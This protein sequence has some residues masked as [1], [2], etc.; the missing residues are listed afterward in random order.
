MKESGE[1]VSMIMRNSRKP[2][3]LG[4]ESRFPDDSHQVYGN[5]P[6]RLVSSRQLPELAEA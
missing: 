6:H 3:R 5:E 2:F 4:G 1:A